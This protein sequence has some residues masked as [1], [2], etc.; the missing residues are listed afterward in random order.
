[1]ILDATAGNRTMYECKQTDSIIYIDM[2]KKLKVKPT[3]FADNT[4]T[5]FLDATFDTIFYDPPHLW[6]NKE[7]YT[8]FYPKEYKKWAS[9]HKPFAF[10]YYG[11]DKYQSREA[12]IAH[13]YRAQ[14]EFARIIK[15]NGLLWLKWNETRIPL[16][17]ILTIFAEWHVLLILRIN[18]ITQTWGTAQTF[19]VCLTKKK[20]EMKQTTL[21]DTQLANNS[22]HST[23]NIS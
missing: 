23:L 16:N 7:G 1:M 18:D 22:T 4:N 17:R 15:P 13:I 3:I 12:L 21:L 9:E 11:W 14:K 5:P 20:G 8:P 6:G 2:E 19:W 10:T